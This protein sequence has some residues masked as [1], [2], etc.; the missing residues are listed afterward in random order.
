[1]IKPI[2]RICVCI[3]FYVGIFAQ[4]TPDERMF[5][6]SNSFWN[7]KDVLYVVGTG[8]ESNNPELK[9]IFN[10]WVSQGRIVKH[11]DKLDSTDF[12]KHLFFFGT[13][14]SYKYLNE[15]LPAACKISFPGFNFGNYNFVK[16]SN[17]FSLYTSDSTRYFQIGNSLPALKSLWTIN[18][19]VSQYIIMEDNS[20]TH[21]GFL[22]NNNFSQENHFDLLRA[23]ENKFKKYETEYYVFSYDPEIFLNSDY[24]KLLKAEDDKLKNIL[25]VLDLKTPQR[26][27]ECFLYKDIAQKYYMSATPGFGNTFT[28]AWQNHSIGLASVEHESIHI[29]FDNLIG[30]YSTFFSEGIVGYYYSSIDSLEWKKNR[31][32]V[33]KENNF[34]INKYLPNDSRFSFSA[35]DYSASAFFVKFLIDQYGFEKYKLFF[36]YAVVEEGLEETYGKTIEQIS[37]EWEGY[38]EKNKI[39]FGPT[40]KMI[41]KIKSDNDSQIFITGDN[42]LFGNWNP[43]TAV[44]EKQDNGVWSKEFSFPEGTILNYKITRGSW[45]NEALDREGNVPPNSIYEV[46]KNDEILIEIKYWKDTL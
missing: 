33:S 28:H 32:N 27:I 3:L 29:L 12:K 43:G 5:K 44:L 15:F 7:C 20:I 34:I 42:E 24:K 17:A 38:F 22:D 37:K 18:C 41:F 26:K 25:K 10:E 40:R 31:L 4:E 2:L 19:E 35:L 39:S 14:N 11:E 8:E 1:M 16:K 46:L 13:I 21:H 9:K 23:R 30:G 36:N 45:D 6:H